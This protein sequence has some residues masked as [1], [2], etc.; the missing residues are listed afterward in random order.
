MADEIWDPSLY[1]RAPVFNL[2][3]GIS[4]ARTLL[5]DSPKTLRGIVTKARKNLE[6]NLSSAQKALADRQRE[7]NVISG[8]DP[9]DIDHAAAGG[10]R[11][12][13]APHAHVR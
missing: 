7:Q 4:L 6:N 8:E 12:V 13:P 9:R 1:T 3:T 10:R 11:R 5:D 2:A